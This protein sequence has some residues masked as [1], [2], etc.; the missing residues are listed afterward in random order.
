M[1]L[2]RG[3][4]KVGTLALTTLNVTD[5]TFAFSDYTQWLSDPQIITGALLISN[6]DC[7][8]TDDLINMTLSLKADTNDSI[9]EIGEYYYCDL[10]NYA[11]NTDC[12]QFRWCLC[13]FYTC[14]SHC[15]SASLDDH[16]PTLLSK[17][18][19]SV[20]SG[21]GEIALA[22][23][24]DSNQNTLREFITAVLQIRSPATIDRSSLFSMLEM[25]LVIVGGALLCLCGC[26]FFFGTIWCC[27]RRQR[28]KK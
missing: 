16:P 24:L 15:S 11:M 6:G 21:D 25:V 13:M 3:T 10:Y 18:S 14:I 26:V 12:C 22:E 1:F 20:W 23:F 19:V 27:R 7:S 17:P 4:E 9:K 28:N 2:H 8:L 5:G